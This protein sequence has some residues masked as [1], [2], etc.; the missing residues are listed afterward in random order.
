MT[1]ALLV[2]QPTSEGVPVCVAALAAAA[3][4]A[5]WDVR[6]ACPAD[7]PLQEWATAGGAEWIDLPLRR[8]PGVGD[9]AQIRRVHS[10]LPSADIVHL[11]SSKAGAVGRAAL[12][13]T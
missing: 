4:D 12:A 2:S 1:R 7:G 13:L 10:M 9:L 8:E 6:V 11:H 5:G 3:V